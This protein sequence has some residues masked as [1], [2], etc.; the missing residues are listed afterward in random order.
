MLIDTG[1]LVALLDSSDGAHLQCRTLLPL[2]PAPLTTTVAC[3]VEAMY[4][5]GRESG[6]RGQKLLWALREEELILLHLST[7]EEYEYMSRLM[8]KYADIPMDLADASLISAAVTLRDSNIFTLDRH[9]Y[10]YRFEDGSVPQ[11]I[12]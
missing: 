12:P 4:F 1:P 5:L 2:L 6:F 3:F 8:K 10:A 9:F 11:I 7:A